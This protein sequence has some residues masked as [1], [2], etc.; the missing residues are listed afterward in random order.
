[1]NPPNFVRQI[2]RDRRENGGMFKSE[3]GVQEVTTTKENRYR[4][5]VT[6]GWGGGAQCFRD[7]PEEAKAEI[8]RLWRKMFG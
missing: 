1:M 8:D 5:Y 7:T 3:V 6:D 2:Y 4:A